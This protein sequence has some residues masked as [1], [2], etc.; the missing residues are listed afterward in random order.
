MICELR[1]NLSQSAPLKTRLFPF[2]FATEIYF[3]FWAHIIFIA[4]CTIF[5][6]MIYFIIFY[7]LL[8]NHLI[9][10]A[11]VFITL[12][13]EYF[14]AFFK[15]ITYAF[16]KQK[17]PCKAGWNVYKGRNVPPKRDLGFMKMGSLL[18]GWIYFHINRFWFFNRILS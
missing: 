7:E 17:R 3:H 13:V 14:S 9:N 12:F 15:N 16:Y 5:M 1:H 11:S 6:F 8:L 2:I 4:A 18:G 10:L